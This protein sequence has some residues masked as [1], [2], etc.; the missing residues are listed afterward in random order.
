MYRRGSAAQIPKWQVQKNVCQL[1][2]KSD[3]VQVS[4]LAEHEEKR[5]WVVRPPAP[6]EASDHSEMDSLHQLLGDNAAMPAAAQISGYNDKER[7]TL[8]YILATSVL[9]LYP[10]I[11]LQ[12]ASCWS[13]DKIFFPRRAGGL[14][15]SRPVAL[16]RPY[17]AVDLLRQ[18]GRPGVHPPSM[19]RYHLH[20]AVLALGIMLLEIATGTRFNALCGKIGGNGSG[21]KEGAWAA[22]APSNLDGVQA[23]KALELLESQPSRRPPS[24]LCEAIR[25]CLVLRPPS[26]LPDQLLFEE[27]PF[28]FYVLSCVVAPLA[29]ALDKAY[30]IRLDSLT[31]D[32]QGGAEG[33][34]EQLSLRVRVPPDGT[35]GRRG[36]ASHAPRKLRRLRLT[37]Y[38]IRFDIKKEVRSTGGLSLRRRRR[39]RRCRQVR[40]PQT[41]TSSLFPPT[42]LPSLYG[43]EALC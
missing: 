30:G 33:S 28:R 40:V 26:Y 23:L 1:L 29:T 38:F 22:A 20:P 14:G 11:W 8:A 43:Y 34:A 21:P 3:A 24:F 31:E 6:L 5:L 35:G 39:F 2:L 4:L 13:S 19:S 27:G 37:D 7:L 18:P 10:G 16:M 36:M 25:A 15:D 41:L 42:F 12:T 17:L 32:E 9:Y